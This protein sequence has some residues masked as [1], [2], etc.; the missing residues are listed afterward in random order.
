MTGE[1]QGGLARRKV[2]TKSWDRFGPKLRQPAT[3]FPLPSYPPHSPPGTRGAGANSVASVVPKHS[4]PMEDPAANRKPPPQRCCEPR[5]TCAAA[6]RALSS[7]QPSLPATP[8]T[9]PAPRLPTGGGCGAARQRWHN[10]AQQQCD[11][12]A[13]DGDRDGEIRHQDRETILH[14]LHAA[15]RRVAR[16]ATAS[17]RGRTAPP[18]LHSAPCGAALRSGGPGRRPRRAS[19]PAARRWCRRTATRW[20][21]RLGRGPA[22]KTGSRAARTAAAAACRRGRRRSRS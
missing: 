3:W 8:V 19:A 7:H 21:A 6:A 4:T 15:G 22:G 11:G 17:L 20:E 13:V 1:D 16:M 14:A 12:A 2:T 18:A 9:S 10:E 5:P